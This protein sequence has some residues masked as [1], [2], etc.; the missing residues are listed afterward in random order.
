MRKRTLLAVVIA[1]GAGPSWAV[2][3]PKTY[4]P[5]ASDTEIKIGQTMPHSGPA[6]INGIIGRTYEAYFRMVNE[7]GGINGRKVSF[8][9]EDDA[10]SPPKTVEATRRLVEQ[11]EVL[12][13]VGSLGTAPQL[14]VQK[15]LN[16]KHIPQI[17]L[18]TGASRW[19]NPKEFPW[20]TPGLPLYSTEARIDAKYVLQVRPGAKV[21]ILYQNDDFGRDF[22]KSFKE[23]LLANQTGASVVAELSYE[24]T[25]PS[26]DSQVVRLSQSGADTFLNVSL[27]KATSQA[28]KKAAE[29]GWK[30]L[31]ILASVSASLPVLQAAGTEASNGI[32]A[33][34]SSK[35]PNAPRWSDDPAVKEFQEFRAKYLPNV[36]ADNYYAFAAWSQAVVLR[37]ILANCGDELTRE[38][39]LRQA[40]SLKG[41]VAPAFLPGVAFAMTPTD[42]TPIRTLYIQKF[43]GK[44]WDLLDGAVSE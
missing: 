39:L 29:L 30:P 34:A 44:D 38:N 15:Y 10:F 36:A 9:S 17:L 41:V 43:N 2:A 5:G 27:G 32:V 23:V 1:I 37:R 28:I 25:E 3:G 35:D 11:E 21:A 16:A 12:G 20:T 6:S 40:T 42:Y 24:L 31:H 33:T 19:N 8:F 4:D 26:V 18:N 7:K 13:F 22:A 14:A